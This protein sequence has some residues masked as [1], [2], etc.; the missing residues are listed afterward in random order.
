MTTEPKTPKITEHTPT[1]AEKTAWWILAAGLGVALIAGL[2]FV[3]EIGK[4][5]GN[6]EAALAWVILGA[7]TCGLALVPALILSGAR[8]LIPR[9]IAARSES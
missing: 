7:S 2:F 3:S 1:S 8:Q 6:P 5:N 4:Y 9:F